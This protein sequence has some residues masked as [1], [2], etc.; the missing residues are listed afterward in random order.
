MLAKRMHV[1]VVVPPSVTVFALVRPTASS[2]AAAR[3]TVIDIG[4]G[5]ISLLLLEG[6]RF[7]VPGLSGGGAR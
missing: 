4:A 2:R 7:D 6:S 1:R 3:G 5:G